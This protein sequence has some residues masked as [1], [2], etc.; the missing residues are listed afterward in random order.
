MTSRSW[1][2]IQGYPG[3][4]TQLT[5]LASSSL[6][7]NGE[8]PRLADYGY[9]YV[10]IIGIKSLRVVRVSRNQQSR[11]QIRLRMRLFQQSKACS[12]SIHTLILIRLAMYQLASIRS[13]GFNL[14]DW[15]PPFFSTHYGPYF[16]CNLPSTH[17]NLSYTCAG[18]CVTFQ[19]HPQAHRHLS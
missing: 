5:N 3:L 12:G 7:I 16:V 11:L 2:S 1:C 6:I 17:R 13:L 19:D 18:S 15:F 4:L 8:D 10:L 9:G 14:T